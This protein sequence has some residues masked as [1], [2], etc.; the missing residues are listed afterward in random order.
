MA[1]QNKE[2]IFPASPVGKYGDV[3]KV[4]PMRCE[5]MWFMYLTGKGWV[6]SS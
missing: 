1:I 4:K 2:Y 6:M 5:Q 3:I